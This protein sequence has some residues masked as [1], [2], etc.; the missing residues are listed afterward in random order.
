MDDVLLH[1]A[2]LKDPK[3][4]SLWGSAIDGPGTAVRVVWRCD[5]EAFCALWGVSDS[6]FW[7]TFGGRS[8]DL[9]QRQA[10]LLAASGEAIGVGVAWENSSKGWIHSL[11]VHGSCQGKGHGKLLLA[12]LLLKLAGLGHEEAFLLVATQNHPAIALYLSM[13]FTAVLESDEESTQWRHTVGDVEVLRRRR[14]ALNAL[15][16]MPL[17]SLPATTGGSASSS[18]AEPIPSAWT[19]RWEE[20][21]QHPTRVSSEINTSFALCGPICVAFACLRLVPDHFS[22]LVKTM[23]GSTQQIGARTREWQSKAASL[24]TTASKRTLQFLSASAEESPAFFDF[25]VCRSLADRLEDNPVLLE[26]QLEFTKTFERELGE[27]IALS[28]DSGDLC[29]TPEGAYFLLSSL[30][31]WT[32]V[33]CT[34]LTPGNGGGDSPVVHWLQDLDGRSS[35]AVLCGIARSY[36]L[37]TSLGG[38]DEGTLTSPVPGPDEA[39]AAALYHWCEFRLLSYRPRSGDEPDCVRGEVWNFTGNGGESFAFQGTSEEWQEGLGVAVVV[40]A[41]P[42]TQPPSSLSAPLNS[43]SE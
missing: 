41:S 31:C 25:L 19:A 29:L 20:L 28:S 21:L 30:G 14:R 13:G 8:E 18:S 4:Q 2:C 32:S 12:H 5:S 33:S 42:T 10:V 23:L 7:Q 15:Q 16:T 39:V 27:K 11:R 9:T 22:E 38:T 17:P 34:V 26:R 37:V 36:D 35:A 1:L 3:L 6:Q 40:V 24:R 43:A